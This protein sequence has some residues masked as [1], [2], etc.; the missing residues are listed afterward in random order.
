MGVNRLDGTLVRIDPAT[1]SV[2]GGVAVGRDP[3]A[4]AVGEGWCGRRRRRGD[5]RAALTRRAARGRALPTGSSSAAIAVAGGAV[6]AAAGAPLAAPGRDAARLLS[7]GSGRAIPIDSLHWEAY[8]TCDTLQLGSLAYDG[9]VAYRRVEGPAGATLVGAL[10]TDAPSPSDDGRTYVFTLRP[11]LRFSDGPPVRPADFRASIERFLRSRAT[12][13]RR[14][15]ADLRGDPR[16]APVLRARAPATSRGIVI[17]EHARTITIHLARPD[18]GFPAQAHLPF[19]YVVPAGSPAAPTTGRP[20]PGTGPYR[21]AAW[22][23]TAAGAV[24]NPYFR[25]DPSRPRGRRVRGSHR[26]PRVA[27]RR[28]SA[29][30]PRSSAARPTSRSSPIRSGR[31]SRRAPPRARGSFTGPGPQRARRPPPTGCSSTS[32][33]P[34]RRR[35]RRRAVNFAIDR[36]QMVALIGGPRPPSGCQILPTEFPGYEPYCRYT[37]ND[38]GRGGPRPIRACA[39][40]VR[41]PGTAGERVVVRMAP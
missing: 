27:E 35:R 33:A 12:S 19:A 34:V 38:A 16:R 13:A 21:V 37:S 41:R 4:V 29:S 18:A 28:S 30:S 15:P 31:L 24:R 39:P 9:L 11:G 40:V 8:T 10:A 14:V 20:P 6:W 26:C 36:A 5:R 2:D 17:D 23:G 3:T 7:C 25:S 22:A 32:A 1:N